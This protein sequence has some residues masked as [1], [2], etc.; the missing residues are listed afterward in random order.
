MNL[1]STEALALVNLLSHGNRIMRFGSD[2]YMKNI[3]TDMSTYF[4]SL[5]AYTCRESSA[6][7]C[8]IKSELG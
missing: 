2:I 8:R 5:N 1:N 4:P 3:P 6:I 7:I